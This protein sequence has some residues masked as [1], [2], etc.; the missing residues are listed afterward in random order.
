MAAWC[1][2]EQR[3]TEK[4][5]TKYE[6][7]F[8]TNRPSPVAFVSIDSCNAAKTVDFN[9]RY[10]FVMVKS[11]LCNVQDDTVLSLCDVSSRKPIPIAF[12]SVY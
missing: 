9:E 8:E 6:A 4:S 7:R 3:Q 10:E 12:S 11:T 1:G 2:I 5:I